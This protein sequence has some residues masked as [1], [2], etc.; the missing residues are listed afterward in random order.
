MVDVG[1][2]DGNA[3]V[4]EFDAGLYKVGWDD[5]DAQ[6][7]WW[8]HETGPS[9]FGPGWGEPVLWCMGGPVYYVPWLYVEH[10]NVL[11]EQLGKFGFY[12]HMCKGLNTL[13]TPIALNPDTR[14]W[15]DIVTLSNLLGQTKFVDR[16]N[17]ETQLWESVGPNDTLDPL[18]AWYIYM[19]EECHSVILLVNVDE[20]HPYAMPTR[21]LPAK[22]SLIAVNPIFPEDGMW[23]DEALISL[24][25]TPMG[26]PGLAQVVSPVVRC[27]EA[28]H[29]VPGMDGEWMEICRGYWV[30]M[31][32]PDTMV[33]FG[34]T[35]LPDKL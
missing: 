4:M 28:W 7:N 23:T 2:L 31:E 5:L 22:W 25:Q 24:K 26:L 14:R 11:D 34:F 35:P 16:W 21:D 29:W 12:V 1:E 18:E 20:G 32:N 8:N 9:G 6:F 3:N 19:F 27:Q 17:A 33:G 10:N 15:E 30:W 13:S